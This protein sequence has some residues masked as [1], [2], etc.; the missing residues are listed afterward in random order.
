MSR[1]CYALMTI[2][3]GPHRDSAAAIQSVQPQGLSRLIAIDLRNLAVLRVG[4]AIVILVDLA[5][6]IGSIEAFCSDQ[7]VLNRELNRWLCPP[8]EG[9]WSLYWL[10]GSTGFATG[11]MAIN[12]VVAVCLLL[13]WQTRLATAACLVLAYSLQ[14]R[15]PLILTA[16]HILLR[17]LLFW[18]LFLPLGAVWSLDANRRNGKS[19]SVGPPRRGAK[20][21]DGYGQV[22]SISS[23]AIMVQV[24][25]MYLFSGLAKWN[26]VWLRGEA[27]SLAMQLDMY[28]KPLGRELLAFPALLVLLTFS[29]LMLETI[30]PLLLWMPIATTQWRAG[31]LVLFWLMHIGI[32]MTMSIGIFSAIAM[33]AWIVFLPR[34]FWEAFA[35]GPNESIPTKSNDTHGTSRNALGLSWVPS[36][37]C[38]VFLL[39]VVALNVAY[40]DP[41]KSKSWF[42]PP[43]RQF[44]NATMTLQQ[45]K[46][47]ERP[48]KD[49]LWWRLVFSNANGSH[50]DAFP[51]G[52]RP[53]TNLEQRPE[54][55][56]IYFSM[57]NQ[58]WRR[59]LFNLATANTQT[60]EDRAQLD[61]LRQRAG[62]VLWGLRRDERSF[63]PS[64]LVEFYC[65]QQSIAPAEWESPIESTKWATIKRSLDNE[66][67]SR[68]Y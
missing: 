42:G 6:R 22:V 66:Q 34:E 58:F 51:P 43:L 14:M 10:N 33:L 25:A 32:W 30:G 18:S 19:G 38:A 23:A 39:Y 63:V 64:G 65:C 45:F 17:M 26:D 44:G 36:I 55:D 3:T 52:P 28:V 56:E 27:M 37:A 67:P 2:T 11:L 5:L 13:G 41:A 46:M 50:I 29:I 7:G 59:L 24:A 21:R 54:P 9:F 49:N 1:L 62:E 35:R 48:A 20:A 15:N 68:S 61:R 12:A 40:I 47:F 4:L 31:L 57:P 8:S 53:L 16:G 60:P